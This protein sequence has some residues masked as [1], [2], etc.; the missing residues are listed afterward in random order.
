[1]KFVSGI[2]VFSLVVIIGSFIFSEANVKIPVTRIQRGDIFITQTETGEVRAKRNITITAPSRVR[3]NLQIIYL[4]E[5]GTFVNEGD[6]LIQFNTEDLESH[7]QDHEERLITLKENLDRLDAEQAKSMSELYADLETI[8]NNYELAQL[9]LESL[10]YESESKKEEAKLQYETAKINYQA[11]LIEIENQ[12]I[13][14]RVNRNDITVD[15]EEDQNDLDMHARWL[16]SMNITAPSTGLVSYRE[17]WSSGTYKKIQEGDN[18]WPRMPLIDL[19]DLSEILVKLMV[20]EIDVEKYMIGQ[21]VIVSLDAYHDQKFNG[22][23]SNISPLV[24][25]FVENLRYFNVVITLEEKNNPIFRPG[26]TAQAEIFLKELTD[27][28]YVPVESVFENNGE[29]IIF[30]KGSGFK[31][32]EITTGERNDRYITI[33]GDIDEGDIVSLIDPAG[34]AEKFGTN[35]KREMKLER[36]RE[37]LE[38]YLAGYT[39]PPDS[40]DDEDIRGNKSSGRKK[41]EQY[42]PKKMDPEMMGSMAEKMLKNPEIKKEYDKRIKSDPSF[43]KDL[44]KRTQFFMEMM[45]KTVNKS[46]Q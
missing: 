44:Q 34:E 8:K 19:P 11:Q 33:S 45:Q 40:E 12:K 17:T 32:K 18:V 16:V 21:K 14:G 29:A 25:G 36:R 24:E 27:V 41:M 26:M 31:P 2:V 22:I 43:E 28:L 5:E 10:K 30:T 39:G 4:I 15:I 46:Q 7:I 20:N 23:V 1:H 37:L 9:T 6:T 42:D 3:Q 38:K 35:L 13:I